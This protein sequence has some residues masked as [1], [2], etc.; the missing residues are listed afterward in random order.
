VK[1]IQHVPGTKVDKPGIYAMGIEEYHSQCCIGPSVSSSGLRRIFDP[2]SSPAHFWNEWSA[3]PDHIEIESSE[4][5]LLGRAA[6][7]LILE[8]PDFD[9]HFVVRPETYTDEKGVEKPWSGNA[10]KCKAWLKRM[11]ESGLSVLTTAQVQ[12]IHGMKTAI[13]AH[14]HAPSLLRGHV[15]I[16]FIWQD[17]ETGLWL[18]SRPD[19]VPAYD[20]TGAD[21]KCVS[22]V[23]DLFISNALRDRGYVQ[24]AALV[25]E[26]FKKL[27]GIDLETFAFVFVEQDRPHCVRMESVAG[28]DYD[29]GWHGNRAALR[30][31]RKCLDTGEWPGPQ[32]SSGDGNA[33]NLSQFARER[34]DRRLAQINEMV[35]A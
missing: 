25:G 11:A 3:N 26:A 1:I 19:A 32:N 5:M 16:S 34:F 35:A 8:E 12:K 22:S 13:L 18:K 31:I 9:R 7:H 30:L 14:D 27:L 23:S 6:H 33:F 20:A 28:E 17:E 2:G 10:N 4:A 24:Q 29:R 21:L 15:E